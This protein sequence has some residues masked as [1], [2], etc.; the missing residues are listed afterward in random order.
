MPAV[1]VDSGPLIALFDSS[2]AYHQRA[3]WHSFVSTAARSSPMWPC[4]PRF[5]ICSISARPRS[6]ISCSGHKTRSTLTF[7]R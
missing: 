3:V 5:V 7:R 6:W 2:D 1:L 4:W